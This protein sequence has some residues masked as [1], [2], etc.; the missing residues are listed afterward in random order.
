MGLSNHSL[1]LL[2]SWLIVKCKAIKLIDIYLWHCL[3]R[4]FILFEYR[5]ISLLVCYDIW[6]T[7]LTRVTT[8]FRIDPA[9]GNNH[10][11]KSNGNNRM[12]LHL[13]IDDRGEMLGC[14]QVG[15]Q[16]FCLW[17]MSCWYFPRFKRGI[18]IFVSCNTKV[19]LDCWSRGGR[20]LIIGVYCSLTF[21]VFILAWTI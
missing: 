18:E 4:K 16:Q 20:R 10:I 6:A 2:C 13:I 15:I 14:S 12:H 1:L 3:Y 17:A 9:S 19:R 5:D 8:M 21:F 7:I 11:N